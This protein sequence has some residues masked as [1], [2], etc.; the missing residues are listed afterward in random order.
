MFFLSLMKEESQRPSLRS[1]MNHTFIQE[2]MDKNMDK[3]RT[4]IFFI[5]DVIKKEN[6]HK[7]ER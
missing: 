5:C 6:D 7:N 1:L 2:N 4:I 3:I